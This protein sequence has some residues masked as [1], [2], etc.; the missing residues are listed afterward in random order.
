[1]GSSRG[2]DTFS[3]VELD[4][5]TSWVASLI[6]EFTAECDCR[7]PDE[8]GRLLA[9]GLQEVGLGQ[10][11]DVGSGLEV[12]E[13]AGATWVHHALESLRTVEVLLLLEEV[14]IA[15]DWDATD[16]LAVL[17]V[18]ERDALIVGEV[19]GC[20]LTHATRDVARDLGDD[21][22]GPFVGA[23]HVVHAVGARLATLHGAA[24][25]RHCLHLCCLG[26]RVLLW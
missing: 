9:D 5:E 18:W 8:D 7:E 21:V 12:A 11:R 4:G 6:W 13:S 25:L 23:H 22:H 26:G 16:G 17:G 10:I 19:W 24:N 15:G 2:E 1:M 3:G 20:V 14:D